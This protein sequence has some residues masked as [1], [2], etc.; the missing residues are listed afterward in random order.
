MKAG[1]FLLKK[2]KKKKTYCE[3]FSLIQHFP[4]YYSPPR[5]WTYLEKA[6]TF[7]AVSFHFWMIQ[8]E[9]QWFSQFPHGLSRL[10]YQLYSWWLCQNPIHLWCV[11]LWCYA[12]CTT[13]LIWRDRRAK[14]ELCRTNTYEYMKDVWDS[15]GWGVERKRVRSDRR[16]CCSANWRWKDAFH[17]NCPPKKA[18]RNRRTSFIPLW[19]MDVTK[20]FW[21]ITLFYE[22]RRVSYVN[23]IRSV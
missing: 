21:S 12:M 17:D 18:K 5:T 9:G 1:Y 20:I 4:Y 3:Y 19:V 10:H 15:P 16:T 8:S 14:Q 13:M 11:L 7:L 22:T 6:H 23:Q 2:K